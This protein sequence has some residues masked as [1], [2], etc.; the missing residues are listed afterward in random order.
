MKSLMNSFRGKGSKKS[1]SPK[2]E[3][4]T[5]DKRILIE[6]VLFFFFE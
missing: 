5:V 2:A 3:D 4:L 6:K 1:Q